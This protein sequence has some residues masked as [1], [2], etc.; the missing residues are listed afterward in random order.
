MKLSIPKLL[1]TSKLLATQAGQQLQDLIYYVAMTLSQVI[2]SLR[3]GITYRDNFDCLIQT[4]SLTDNTAQVIN[5]GTSNKTVT[6][7]VPQQVISTTVAMTSMVWYINSSGSLV[8]IPHFLGS[9]TTSVNVV[10]R[11]EF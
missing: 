2:Q 7:V 4:V 10:L 8:V 11:I 5:R 3:N 6:G 1:D 9:P